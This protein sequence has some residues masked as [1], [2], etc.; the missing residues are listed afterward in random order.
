MSMCVFVTAAGRERTGE[1]DESPNSRGVGRETPVVRSSK[2]WF[3]RA[4]CLMDADD[5]PD[6]VLAEV[7]LQVVSFD[8]FLAIESTCISATS[9]PP[10]PPSPPTV[11]LTA[12]WSPQLGGMMVDVVLTVF[13]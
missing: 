4:R 3:G 2:S 8:C 5:V 6:V 13:S 1:N 11:G 12:S 7:L 10:S 9:L